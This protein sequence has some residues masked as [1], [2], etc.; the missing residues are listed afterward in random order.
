MNILYIDHYAGSPVLGMEYRP[1]YLAR[2]WVREG[3]RVRIIAASYAHTRIRQPKVR[4]IIDRQGFDGVEYVFL[5]TPEYSGNGWGRILNILAFV[6]QLY[7]RVRDVCK[8]F[9][10]D[11]VIASSGYPFDMGPAQRIAKFHKAKLVYEVSELWPES[12]QEIWGVS[13]KHPFAMLSKWGQTQ[14]CKVCDA[15]V[16]MLPMAT[17]YLEKYGLE[18]TPFYYIPNGIDPD[19]WE[20]DDEGGD[21]GIDVVVQAVIDRM[22]AQ[23]RMVV[24]YAGTH[25]KMYRLKALVEA[26]A[27]LKGEKIAFIC[28]GEGEMRGALNDY[29]EELGVADN[30]LFCGALPKRQVPRFLKQMDVLFMGAKSLD[31]YRYGVSFNKIYDYM[32]A[33]RPIVMAV[34]AGNDMVEEAAGGI[35]VPSGKAED[36]AQA[37]RQMLAMSDLERDAYGVEAKAHVLIHNTYPVLARQFLQAVQGGTNMVIGS[38]S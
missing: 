22:K 15:V 3:H 23:G 32:M 14:A 1:Y 9:K 34:K 12:M 37:L 20:E 29:A 33:G 24:G 38:P 16:S 27:M 35:S 28:I 2:Q 10:P 30:V 25:G 21:A 17:D 11:I 18:N 19:E 13:A 7:W 6:G 36:I 4:G 31:I 26:A 5:K 8:T